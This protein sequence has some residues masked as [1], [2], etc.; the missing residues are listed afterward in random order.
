MTELWLVRHGQT[1][2]NVEGRYNGQEDTPLNEVGVR[3]AEETA[4][5]L[6]GESFTAVYA[7]DLQRAYR[8][9][10]II[11]ARLGLPIQ[12]DTRLREIHQGEFQGMLVT[13]IS[14]RYAVVMQQ[15]HAN[16]ATAHAPGGE[17][18]T[19]VA[20]RLAAA[21]DDIARAHP[22]ERVLVVSHGMALATLIARARGIPLERAYTLIP[23]NASPVVIEW[24]ERRGPNPP[25]PLP[26]P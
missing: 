15:W 12:T 20:A 6:A 24:E 17:S 4:G 2:W 7:S 9:A 10:E 18:V 26:L 23:E 19:Q 8:T 22:G 3:Q 21:A 14:E 11:T 5:K 1:D 25:A 13:E 16:P